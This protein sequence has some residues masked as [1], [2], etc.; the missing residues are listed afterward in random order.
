MRVFSEERK[1]VFYDSL[2]S[3]QKEAQK[4]VKHDD[5]SVCAVVAGEQTLGRGR[6]GRGWYSPHGEC[7]AVSFL[8][9]EHADWER[10][11]LL[12]MAIGLGASIA[13]DT[14]I[15]WPNDLVLNG[16]KV[17]GVL[18]EIFHDNKGR[19]IP[20]IGL[21]VN[22]RVKSFPEEIAERATSLALEGREVL[23][24]EDSL[25]LLKQSLPEIPEPHNWLNL[26]SFW[27]KRDAT[28]SKKYRLQDG[29][30]GIAIGINKDGWLIV[31]VEGRHIEV[32]SAEAFFG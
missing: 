6:F 25:N 13:F 24:V 19:A 29:R 27:A 17:G 15:A 4:Y 2:E 21:G 22:L 9:W 12:A 8:L 26:A 31:E 20:V 1:I 23:G 10:M 7:L 32:P 30:A 11:E 18:G 3:T 16:K 5:V 28:T 14:Q